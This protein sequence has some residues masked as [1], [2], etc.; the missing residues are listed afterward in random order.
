MIVRES[1]YK[2]SPHEKLMNSIDYISE[3]A[4]DPCSANSV[5]IRYNDRFDKDLIQLESF[6][7]Y[8]NTHGIEDAGVAIANVCEAN[9]VAPT[10][11]AFY[12]SEAN[13][14]ADDDLMNATN[15]FIENGYQVY[16]APVSTS[17][18]AYRELDEALELDEDV[19]T[20]EESANLQAYCE[21]EIPE[22]IKNKVSSA[23]EKAKSIKTSSVEALSKK[24]VA[25]K[26]KLAEL[27]RSVSR[28]AGSTK[29]KLMAQI[30]KLKVVVGKLKEKLASL[31]SSKPAVSQ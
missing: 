11:L 7:A 30:E 18:L 12:V 26:Q 8:A 4:Y 25:A 3:S 5:I 23:K 10:K 9:N 14:Y 27:Q 13:C 21:V 15:L 17:S 31:K 2:L 19:Q 24:Y 20:F 16:L 1:D 22:G 28:T 29:V 6:C